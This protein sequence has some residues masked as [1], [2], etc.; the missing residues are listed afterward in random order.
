MFMVVLGFACI[1]TVICQPFSVINVPC[2][3][4]VQKAIDDADPGD[5][6]VFRGHLNN[7]DIV[8]ERLESAGFTGLPQPPPPRRPSSLEECCF[9]ETDE[10]IFVNKILYIRGLC[11][12]LKAGVKRTPVMEV[13]ANGVRMAYVRAVG[14]VGS[15]GTDEGGALIVVSASYFS[16]R[17]STVDFANGVGIRVR[18]STATVRNIKITR[19]AGEY[20][21]GSLVSLVGRGKGQILTKQVTL[22]ALLAENGT[23]GGVLEIRDGVDKVE[24]TDLKAFNSFSCV[25]ILEKDDKR[26]VG[27]GDIKVIEAHAVRSQWVVYVAVVN[28]KYTGYFDGVYATECEQTVHVEGV[29]GS[30]FHHVITKD[31]TGGRKANQF[32]ISKCKDVGLAG[33]RFQRGE[34]RTAFYVTSSNDIHMFNARVNSDDYRFGMIFDESSLT[35]SPRLNLTEVDFSRASVRPIKYI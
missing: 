19:V 7:A 17:D 35:Y 26:A 11:L 32:Y 25:Q 1:S 6:L 14:N 31:P 27:K 5:R 10:T 34:S 33:I 4:D 9:F 28:D 3:S 8:N 30:T 20:N 23:E 15:A 16:M 12:K 29:R 22:L 2:G 24:A 13:T 18:P 21:L